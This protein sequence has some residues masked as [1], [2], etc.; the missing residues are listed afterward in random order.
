MN[1]C[2]G[3]ELGQGKVE[4]SFVEA[5][6]DSE[7]NLSPLLKAMTENGHQKLK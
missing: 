5:L 6:G 3:R 4:V 7:K 2:R 1:F